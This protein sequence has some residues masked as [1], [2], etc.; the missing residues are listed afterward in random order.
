MQKK[1]VV[2]DMSKI[3]RS[4]NNFYATYEKYRQEVL[5]V[6]AFGAFVFSGFS[7]LVANTPTAKKVEA[8]D[9]RILGLEQ[10][11]ERTS[12]DIET[13]NHNLTRLTLKLV[14]P[15]TDFSNR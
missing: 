14:G 3:R 6:F 7:F 12:K 4:L 8:H 5:V 11:Y 9:T 10:A 15:T 13:I 1:T 2:N